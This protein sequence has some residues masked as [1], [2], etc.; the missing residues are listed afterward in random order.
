MEPRYKTLMVALVPQPR[1]MPPP[2]FDKEQLQRVFAEVIE[3]HPYQAFE[4][5][6][7]G[8][9]A[10]FGN[11]SDDCVELR[12]ALFQIQARM[13]HADLLTAPMAA[14]KVNAIFGIA[15]ERLNVAAFL[16]CAIQIIASADAPEGDAKR[17]VAERLLHDPEQALELGD[18]YFGGG[19][20]FRNL[21]QPVAGAED[22][23]NIE[24]DVNDNRLLFIDF[25]MARVAMDGPISLDQMSEWVGEAFDFISDPTMRL[26]SR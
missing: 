20:R 13:D 21:V 22:N 4:F 14:D 23:L 8:R 1:Q 15:A 19:V 3:R 17:F 10:Q 26:L 12:P 6:P 11:D 25:Q 5:L 7:S 18:G 9:G 24:P 16:Q 2:P